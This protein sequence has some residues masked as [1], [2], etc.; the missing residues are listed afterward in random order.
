MHG[1]GDVFVLC[2]RLGGNA[3]WFFL[4][5]MIADLSQKMLLKVVSAGTVLAT[6][7]QTSGS[8]TSAMDLINKLN[9]EQR[10]K[11][12]ALRRYIKENRAIWRYWTLSHCIGCFSFQLCVVLIIQT[13]QVFSSYLQ[14][15]YTSMSILAT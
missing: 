10:Q 12:T 4:V 1:R 5:Q 8:M 7:I 2:K 13:S 3:W 6:L 14:A 15:R 11:S 9:F